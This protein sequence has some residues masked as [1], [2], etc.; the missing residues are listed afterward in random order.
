MNRNQGDHRMK[1]MN[2]GQAAPGQLW[3]KYRES[4][5][6]TALIVLMGVGV[7]FF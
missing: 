4:I 2:H 5:V 3:R 6:G 1:I 7:L